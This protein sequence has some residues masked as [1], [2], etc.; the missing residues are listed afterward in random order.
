[1][2][3]AEFAREKEKVAAIMK[4]KQAKGEFGGLLLNYLD[5]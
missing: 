1:M 5:I 3:G 2:S 4:E